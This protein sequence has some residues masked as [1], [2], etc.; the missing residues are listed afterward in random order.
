MPVKHDLRTIAGQNAQIAEFGGGGGPVVQGVPQLQARIKSL[1]YLPAKVLKAW[2]IETVA[3]AKGKA[4]KRTGNLARSIHAGPLTKQS[5]QVE[6]SAGYAAY[7]ELGT[8]PHIIRPKYAKV[9]AW[10]GARRLS[11]SLRSGSKATNFAMIVHHP[12][13]K[14]QPFLLPAA[15]EAQQEVKLSKAAVDLWNAAA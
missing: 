13:T 11:G 6:A 4:P 10:G 8:K 12:G 14:P 9:L 7:V 5:A 1:A 2:Q 3:R 15:I